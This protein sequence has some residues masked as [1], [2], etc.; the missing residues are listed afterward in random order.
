MASIISL[1]I[2]GTL[3]VWQG[4]VF[5]VP[6]AGHS[7]TFPTA[8]AHQRL[9]L[10]LRT[11]MRQGNPAGLDRNE[12]VEIAL[13]W[14]RNVRVS[15]AP[16]LRPHPTPSTFYRL[17]RKSDGHPLAARDRIPMAGQQAAVQSLG[18]M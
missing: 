8:Q 10:Q 2:P 5:D 12:A 13:L 11:S 3:K 9:L 4:G 18:P 1:Y 15:L 17:A 16:Y 6:G 7:R 14:V